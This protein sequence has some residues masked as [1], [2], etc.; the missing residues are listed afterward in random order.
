VAPS[1]PF[2]RRGLWFES[3][4]RQRLFYNLY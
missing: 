2:G 3:P 1:P 4:Q